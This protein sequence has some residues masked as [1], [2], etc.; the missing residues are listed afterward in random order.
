M[1]YNVCIMSY[2]LTL[3]GIDEQTKSALL[4]GARSKGISLNKYVVETLK[5]ST[6]ITDSHSKYVALSSFFDKHHTSKDD[7]DAFYEAL[8]WSDKTS[9]RKQQQEI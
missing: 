9:I 8:S 5:Q 7:Q 4:K 1:R 6:G 2:Q 3:R